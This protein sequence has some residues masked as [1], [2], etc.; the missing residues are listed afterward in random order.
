MSEDFLFTYQPG[1]DLRKEKALRM[2]SE[3]HSL[4]EVRIQLQISEKTLAA[5][6][7]CGLPAGDPDLD[8]LSLV[9]GL[10]ERERQQK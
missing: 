2:I 1:V 8:Q 10:S 5:W 7:R 9:D 6:L 3:G 4:A